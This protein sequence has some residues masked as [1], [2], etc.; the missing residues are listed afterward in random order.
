MEVNEDDIWQ[1]SILIFD[2]CSILRLYEWCLE[3][4]F[5]LQDIFDCKTQDI[6][7]LEQV[8]KEVLNIYS[9]RIENKKDKYTDAI[10]KLLKAEDKNKAMN[11]L[12]K[13]CD[14][15]KYSDEFLFLL[16]SYIE[17]KS[18]Y[19]EIMMF[20]NKYDEQSNK[21]IESTKLEFILNNFFTQEYSSKIS[22]NEL[23]K[24]YNK[25][26]QIGLPGCKD[27]G[28]NKNSNGDYIILNQLVEIANDKDKDITFITAD[29]KAD[30]FPFNK[31]L[32]KRELNPA[33]VEWFNNEIINE[34]KISVITLAEIL[35]ISK[36]Y[37]SSDISRLVDEEIIYNLINETYGTWYPEELMDKITEYIEND[38]DIQFQIENAIDSCL[39]YLEFGESEDYK[40]IDIDYE[41][42]DD[43][44]IVNIN[45]EFFLT[46]DAS[47]HCAGEDFDLGS[48]SC[49]FSGLVNG[50]IPIYW[51]SKN[52][53]AISIGSQLEDISIEEIS[54]LGAKPL[55]SNEDGYD[56]NEPDEYELDDYYDIDDYYESDNYEEIC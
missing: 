29:V 14:G 1:E 45:L 42:E 18:S 56:E 11:T 21:Y 54:F 51:E 49:H 19:D 43:E 25:D 7:L 36:D 12:R 41:I 13:Q 40:V 15:Y 5:E 6:V 46:I 55:Y 34:S 10:N 8:K 53:G 35:T 39:D 3:K 24:K 30:W 32:K 27:R 48:P 52:T 9:S 38:G 4:S 2:S 33:A 37:I 44:V 23:E 26:I 31:K 20:V 22:E 28:K 16:Q 47:A 17:E 50:R